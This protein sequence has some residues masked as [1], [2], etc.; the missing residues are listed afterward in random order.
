MR[1]KAVPEGLIEETQ[2]LVRFYL[3]LRY[4]VGLKEADRLTA[5]QLKTLL[6]AL[7]GG[8]NKPPYKNRG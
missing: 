7:R 3:F 1:Y 4:E 6:G 2:A 5:S 8:L